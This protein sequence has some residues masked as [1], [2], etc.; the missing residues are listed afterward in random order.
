[1]FTQSVPTLQFVWDSTSLGL[2][3]ECARKY[4]YSI[5]LGQIS[6]GFAIHLSFGIYYHKALEIYE[7]AIAEDQD[8]ET[9]LRE[10]VRYC[11]TF[12]E[13]RGKN[14]LPYDRDY[15]NNPNKTIRT[16]VRS[17]IWYCDTFKNDPYKTVI[18]NNGK[19]ALELKNLK[20]D[21]L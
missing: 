18:L 16:L 19:P 13:R 17:V 1:M 9:A 2:L 10:S 15:T 11:M 8:H 6:S 5:I 12:G 20:L 14:W 4:Y 21:D 7:H 3:K